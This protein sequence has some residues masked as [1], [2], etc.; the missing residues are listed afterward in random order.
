MLF[1]CCCLFVVVCWLLLFCWM[2][3]NGRCSLFVVD[4]RWLFAVRRLSWFAV[5]CLMTVLI[6]GRE[7]S[8]VRCAL[9]VLL[10]VVLLAFCCSVCVVC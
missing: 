10:C 5:R 6:V 2:S 9:F 4:V 8:V 3:V 1:V 7:L